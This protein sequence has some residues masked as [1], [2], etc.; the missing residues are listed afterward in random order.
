MFMSKLALSQPYL[1]YLILQF[2]VPFGEL[3]PDCG[4]LSFT[5]F[6]SPLSGLKLG[7]EVSAELSVLHLI[8][9]TFR[10]K[11]GSLDMMSVTETLS[12]LLT[13]IL[14][15]SSCMFNLVV[16][17]RLAFSLLPP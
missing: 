17:N 16:S 10:A 7:L 15:D 12:H 9:F 4:I 1:S 13:L 8:C 6:S 14:F 5:R 3:G 11:L 2:R